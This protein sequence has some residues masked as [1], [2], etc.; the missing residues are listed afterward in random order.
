[1]NSYRVCRIFHLPF[2]IGFHNLD[3]WY[4]QF[5]VEQN[6]C[7]SLHDGISGL[8][9]VHKQFQDEWTC[10]TVMIDVRVETCTHTVSGFVVASM[11]DLRC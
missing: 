8:R 7:V 4:E 6:F 11:I 10:S 1:M 5:Q 3:M 9:H 2:L